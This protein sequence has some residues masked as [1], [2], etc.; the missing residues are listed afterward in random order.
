M[1]SGSTEDSLSYYFSSLTGLIFIY[2][3]GSVTINEF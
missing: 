3:F 1:T 2:I